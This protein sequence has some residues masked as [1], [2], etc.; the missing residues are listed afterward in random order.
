VAYA[1]IGIYCFFWIKRDAEF[2]TGP[3]VIMSLMSLFLWPI[4]V[5]IWMLVRGEEHMTD[6][7]AKQ[8]HRDY[9]I[10]MRTKKDKDLFTSLPKPAT[11]RTGHETRV[12]QEQSND[13]EAVKQGEGPFHDYNIESLIENG[14]LDEALASAISMKKV[15]IDMEEDDR[16]A[17]YDEYIQ[18][19]EHAKRS[20]LD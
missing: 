13:I 4:M 9:L 2:R 15:A 17:R 8:S 10:Y 5:F 7:A 18:R 6:I 11:S 14:Q 1:L 16:V 12:S 19:I 20:E 3:W